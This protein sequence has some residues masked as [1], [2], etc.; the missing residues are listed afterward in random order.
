MEIPCP[1]PSKTGWLGQKNTA[2]SSV[3]PDFTLNFSCS[4]IVGY[5]C[6]VLLINYCPFILFMQ[7]IVL[8][9]LRFA[10]SDNP[11]GILKLF[12]AHLVKGKVALDRSTH[13][14]RW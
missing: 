3:A 6:S 9:V 11:F 14:S 12:L 10:V 1:H 5:I 4:S 7:A 13:Q 2:D 8:S